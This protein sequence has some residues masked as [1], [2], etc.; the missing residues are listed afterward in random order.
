[1]FLFSPVAELCKWAETC[2]VSC[3][4]QGAFWGNAD[5]ADQT[6][7]KERSSS[8]LYYFHY[9]SQPE[10][11]T[12]ICPANVLMPLRTTLSISSSIIRFS[13]PAFMNHDSYWMD[14]KDESVRL[15]IQFV[16][17]NKALV[18]SAVISLFV[19]LFHDASSI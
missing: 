9:F 18:S 12:F 2:H 3:W 4:C 6:L 1:M 8:I 15:K 13:K 11:I 17:C 5:Q 19:L 10:K 16:S 7:F 14:Q